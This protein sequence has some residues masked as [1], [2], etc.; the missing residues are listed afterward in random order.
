MGRDI[1]EAH[2]LVR[3]VFTQASETLNLDL[4]SLCFEGPEEVLTDTLN[5]QPAILTLSIA[6]WRILS[7]REDDQHES[8]SDSHSPSPFRPLFC[9]GHSMG[10]YS[11]LV[12]A[13]ALE[14][15][16]ALQLVRRRGELMEA[17]GQEHRGGMA[18]VIGLDAAAVER[19][20][21]WAQAETG[22]VVGIANDNSPGQIVVSGDHV[23]LKETAA[24]AK[25]EGA[26]RF[27]HLAVS[28]AGHSPLMASAAQALR[29]VLAS[30]PIRRSKTPVVANVGA[31]PIE[32]PEDIRQELV[33]Q[34][35]SPV[36]WVESV[37]YMIAQGVD[38]FVEVGPGDVLRGL[39]RRIDGG[40]KRKGVSDIIKELR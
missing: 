38:T 11:A 18:A 22:G 29:G 30:T 4:A 23:T 13:G 7:D 36:R 35:T 16:D 8:L 28:V 40:V 19:V 17:A 1:Y 25:E 6:L 12:A 10:E 39:I 27:I 5:A 37:R 20:C 33:A 31:R 15:S 9:A 2:A 21:T 34:L 26:R 14:F 32:E 24:L 3:Q